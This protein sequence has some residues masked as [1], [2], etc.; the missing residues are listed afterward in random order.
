VKRA[1]SSLDAVSIRTGVFLRR[2]P[3]ARILVL[4]YMVSLTCC[5]LWEVHAETGSGTTAFSSEFHILIFLVCRLC[6][7]FHLHGH[8]Y[9]VV[10]LFSCGSERNWMHML[11]MS[12]CIA[13]PNVRTEGQ[14]TRPLACARCGRNAVTLEIDS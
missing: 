6:M 5:N 13:N 14:A 2:Y 3:L 7:V 12:C 1:Y 4:C 9:A 10:S 11:T 8:T